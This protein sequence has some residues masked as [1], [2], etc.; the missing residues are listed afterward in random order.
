M[1]ETSIV[2]T[3]EQRVPYSG[4]TMK[5]GDRMRSHCGETPVT[6][7]GQGFV[8]VFTTNVGA[9]VTFSVCVP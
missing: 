6:G 9:P 8:F 1:P 2:K 3:V 7:H 5:I 4:L